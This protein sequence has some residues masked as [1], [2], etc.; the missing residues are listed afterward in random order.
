MKVRAHLNYKTN[1]ARILKR[2]QDNRI[3]R[4]IALFALLG[5]CC[6]HCGFADHRALQIDHVNGG[7]C[8]D[9]NGVKSQ[10]HYRRVL[11]SVRAGEGKFQLLCA[12][13]NWIKR[14]ERG[15]SR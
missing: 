6:K 11:K 9:R 1:K 2:Q 7:G 8:K 5:G 12:N 13:C 4:K 10:Q 3:E 15:E 14:W